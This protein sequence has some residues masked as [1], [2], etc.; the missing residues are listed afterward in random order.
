MID[1]LIKKGIIW[2]V[3]IWISL[4]AISQIHAFMNPDLEPT[5][6]YMTIE[7][8]FQQ[9]ISNDPSRTLSGASSA[10]HGTVS[11][12]S[13]ATKYSSSEMC[14]IFMFLGLLC[15]VLAR[16]LK[17]IIYIPEGVTLLL[18]G[19]FAGSVFLNSGTIGE[20]ETWAITIHPHF[21]MCLFLPGLVFES[22]YNS[23]SFTLKRNKWQVLL[24]AGP[25]ALCNAL[26]L[27]VILRYCFGYVH[28]L[29]WSQALAIGSALALTD[30][31]AIGAM[32]RE[33]KSSPMSFNIMLEDESHFSDG[34]AMVIFLIALKLVEGHNLTFGWAFG[35][36]SQL[37]FGGI[38]MGI[39]FGMVTVFLVRFIYNDSIMAIAI[40]LCSM[41]SCFFLCEIVLHVS[42]VLAVVFLGL[43]MSVY[44]KI[45]FHEKLEHSMH[46]S[47]ELIVF[48]LESLLFLLC[49][50]FIGEKIL[51][52]SSREQYPKDIWKSLLYY[53]CV[54]IVRFMILLVIWP[55]MQCCGSKLNLK[56]IIGL[57]I[58]GIRG[59]ISIVLAMIIAVDTADEERF[60]DLAIWYCAVVVFCSFQFQ[61]IPMNWYLAKLEINDVDPAHSKSKVL[62][63]KENI[64]KSQQLESELKKKAMY[65]Y[66]DW[67]T[68]A[69]QT[70]IKNDVLSALSELRGVTNEQA[71][72]RYNK[73]KDKYLLDQEKAN[74]K[75]SKKLHQSKS[76]PI[77]ETSANRKARKFSIVNPNAAKF[78][79]ENMDSIDVKSEIRYRI[80]RMMQSI[81]V[82]RHEH[83]L[84][85]PLAFK[86]IQNIIRESYE[87][88]FG[89]V[90]IWEN[91]IQYVGNQKFQH[92]LMAIGRIRFIGN[93]FRYFACMLIHYQYNLMMN[94][95]EICKEIISELRN[96]EE[97]AKV[98]G[99]C[100][101]AHYVKKIAIEL[102]DDIQEIDNWIRT[103]NKRFESVIVTVHTKQAAN[104]LLYNQLEMYED[105]LKSG[106]QNTVEFQHYENKIISRIHTAKRYNPIL[107]DIGDLTCTL[108]L[109]F[110]FLREL[111]QSQMKELVLHAK[112]KE[113][114]VYFGK[115]EVVIKANNSDNSFILFVNEGFIKEEIM[116]RKGDEICK[117]KKKSTG[118]VCN[119]ANIT[120]PDNK[121]VSNVIVIENVKGLAISVQLLRKFM[122]E[123]SSFNEHIYQQSLTTLIRMMNDKTDFNPFHN[124]SDYELYDISK[125]SKYVEVKA[126]ESVEI[127]NGGLLVDGEMTKRH[128]NKTGKNSFDETYYY[129]N[130]SIIL[131]S[132]LHA[133][134]ITDCKMQLFELKIF[135]IEKCKDGH[136]IVDVVMSKV[137]KRVRKIKKQLYEQNHLTGDNLLTNLGNVNSAHG[138]IECADQFKKSQKKTT[139]PGNISDLSLDNKSRS[140]KVYK[141]NMKDICDQLNHEYSKTKNPINQITPY[142]FKMHSAFKIEEST[143]NSLDVYQ[144][145][146]LKRNSNQLTE[147]PMDQR[148]VPSRCEI[149]DTNNIF[150]KSMPMRLGTM[151]NMITDGNHDTDIAKVKVH[152]M[153][154]EDEVD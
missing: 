5:N 66:A 61:R 9:K 24:M 51:T 29:H 16:F 27:A 133:N 33:L 93:P 20:V 152:F 101:Y 14:I 55:L 60:R 50:L 4:I 21:L 12:G 68:V 23:D 146:R 40:T 98:D 128:I 149:L 28:D 123:N 121:T 134:A 150:E 86:A 32:L 117:T 80:Y 63:R 2:G 87:T 1:I 153:E 57:T 69:E 53:P 83:Y 88:R 116:N 97:E 124:Q 136:Y 129:S 131:P 58:G 92:C 127:D 49:G 120:H 147:I 151:D 3:G 44:G 75:A 37:V 135:E 71:K 18:I 70:G 79:D 99:G 154:S 100:A 15:G 104:V 115:G 74:I 42:G 108:D 143:Q 39:L 59:V 113:A 35:Y 94:L 138:I 65:G 144:A 118:W 43:L 140:M 67:D 64:I 46:T 45:N 142:L 56:T 26:L 52:F 132:Q 82:D 122:S 30:P 95:E 114:N 90:D 36:F 6:P 47:F 126:G 137:H 110:P 102:A 85:D 19:I 77:E 31:I 107:E 11:G 103:Y 119:L 145:Q 41:Y 105:K 72:A 106:F 76:A 17:K 130:M 89:K 81:L 141:S 125:Y 111:S 112:Q 7:S 84:C 54:Y 22:A 34:S 62:I 8:K 13:H 48:C 96:L 38:G 109:D 25:G 148:A 78:M 91:A 73:R 139:I 10:T